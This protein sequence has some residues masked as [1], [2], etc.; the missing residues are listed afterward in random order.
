MH[1]AKEPLTPAANG[2]LQKAVTDKNLTGSP[3]ELCA[4]AHSAPIVLE[5]ASVGSGQTV[6]KLGVRIQARFLDRAPEGSGSKHWTC[7]ELDQRRWVGRS[8]SACKKRCALL[9]AECIM[10]QHALSFVDAAHM[11][12]NPMA[13]ERRRC[14]LACNKA[15][16]DRKGMGGR[17]MHLTIIAGDPHYPIGSPF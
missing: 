6:T 13:Q 4:L 12:G 16:Q 15:H 17:T 1:A 11:T 5:D 3:L 2:P 9:Q 7:G 14:I 10:Y 8:G